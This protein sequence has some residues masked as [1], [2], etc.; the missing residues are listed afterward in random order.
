V[1]LDHKALGEGAQSRVVVGSIVHL[2]ISELVSDAALVYHFSDDRGRLGA[3]MAFR[4]FTKADERATSASML[5]NPMCH[6]AEHLQIV[7][8][9]PYVHRECD[10]ADARLKS[11]D[12]IFLALSVRPKDPVPHGVTAR[13]Q[14]LN[15]RSTQYDHLVQTLARRLFE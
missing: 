10:L 11:V 6:Y 4:Q 9:A 14:V 5:V 8:S 15:F 7:W 2:E 12:D 3:C 1:L 13:K